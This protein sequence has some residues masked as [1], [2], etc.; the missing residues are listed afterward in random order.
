MFCCS[1]DGSTSQ[2]CAEFL[3]P[4]I[5]EFDQFGKFVAGLD[6]EKRQRNIRRPEGLFCQA[7]QA[8]GILAAGEQQ[9]GALEFPGDLTHDVNRFR[10]QKLQMIKMV[11]AHFDT[12][13]TDL[14]R[15][16]K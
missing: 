11:T 8:D 9:G 13:F 6:V 2:F 10:F 1:H 5:A 15:F 16:I 12:D 7:Q 4:A 3:R 14:H